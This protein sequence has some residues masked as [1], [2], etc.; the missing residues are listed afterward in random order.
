MCVYLCAWCLESVRKEKETARVCVFA[1]LWGAGALLLK[2]PTLQY[3][4]AVYH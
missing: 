4:W 1:Y 2:L 3:E